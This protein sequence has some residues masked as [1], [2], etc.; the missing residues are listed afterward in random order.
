[1]YIYRLNGFISE[2]YLVLILEKQGSSHCGE[3]GMNLTSI[4]EDAGSIPGLTHWVG[5]LALP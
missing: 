3:A 5:D 1:M 2:P 4:D